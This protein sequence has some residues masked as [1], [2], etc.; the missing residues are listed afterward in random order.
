[1]KKFLLTALMLLVTIS[2]VYGKSLQDASI[3]TGEKSGPAD[4]LA[5]I[6]DSDIVIGVDFQKLVSSK[7]YTDFMELSQTMASKVFAT[8][9][10]LKGQFEQMMNE[11]LN[12]DLNRQFRHAFVGISF[13]GKMVYVASGSFDREKVISSFTIQAE[14]VS[15]ETEN[16]NNRTIQLINVKR[17]EEF[18]KFKASIAKNNPFAALQERVALAFL[19]SERL[20]FGDLESVKSVIDIE[21]GKKPGLLA[22]NQQLI[23]HL[24]NLDSWMAVRPFALLSSISER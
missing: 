19:G 15:I 16:Y 12:S 24:S 22:G 14:K 17:S 3:N 11:S 2:S 13:S 10:K 20:V 9:P 18:E 5:L 8:D 7:T 1:M 23:T 6:P 4:L 21:A